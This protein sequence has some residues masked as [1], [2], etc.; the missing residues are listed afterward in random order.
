[1]TKGSQAGDQV[2]WTRPHSRDGQMVNRVLRRRAAT[3]RNGARGVQN[4]R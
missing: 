4:G 3:H 2:S 1:M